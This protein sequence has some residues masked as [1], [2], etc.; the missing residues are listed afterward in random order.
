MIP[1]SFNKIFNVGYP[2]GIMKKYVVMSD[3]EKIYASML[4]DIELAKKEIFLETYIFENDYIGR[5]F[6]EVLTRKVKEG[7]RV[8]LLIDSWGSKIRKPFFKDLIESG[9]EVRFFRELRYV[10]RWFNANHERNH[11][12]LLLVDRRVS[13]V[14]SINI[15]NRSMKW[16]ELVLRIDSNLTHAF[17]RLFLRQWKHFNLI[18]PKKMRKISHDEFEVIPDFPSQIDRPTEKKYRRLIGRAKKEILIETPYFI[19]S[20]II[21]NALRRAI[22]R[23]V[24]IKIV[25]PRYSDVKLVD[26]LRDRYLGKLYLMGADM[27]YYPHVLHSKLLIVDEEFF[28]L[29][30]SNLDYRSFIYQYEVNLLGRDKKILRD[31]KKYF[32]QNLKESKPFSYRV[33][34]NRTLKQR[35]VGRVL[36]FIEELF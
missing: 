29:G 25:L 34:K 19:P 11:R 35:L 28:L 17:R 22:E 32:M 27:Y 33:W 21:R 8:R 13:Y 14:G 20:P 7:L 12:K 5:K 3:A 4:K 23:G 1:L 2:V 10:I 9:G 16:R 18:I 30:S 24:K 36:A 15:T 6:R 31:L 26:V